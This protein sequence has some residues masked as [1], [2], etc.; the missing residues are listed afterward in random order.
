MLF[1]GLVSVTF[2]PL[3]P[4]AV[5]RLA[6]AA[7]VQAIEWGGDVHVPHGD[8][9]AAREVRQRTESAGLHVA[10]YGSYFRFQPEAV[11]EPVL[12]TA[13]E[14]GAPLIRVWAGDRPSAAADAAYREHIAAESRRIAD[15]AAALGVIIAYEH[16]ADTLTDTTASAVALLRAAGRTRS[17]WQPPH[18]QPLDK[19]LAGLQAIL[20]WLANLHVFSWEHQSKRR[21]PLAHGESLWPEVLRIAAQDGRDH[22]ALLE[23]VAG[24]DPAQL[25]RDAATLNL[26][27]AA[28]GSRYQGS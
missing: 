11:F 17:L 1:S 4:A 25:L 5:V 10:A 24:D 14:L 21:L 2:R 9:R 20:P 7:G 28:S 26:W 22:A 23:F 12:E 6:V 3:P 15:L 19:Q 27:I 8:L 13:L 16:H 18:D